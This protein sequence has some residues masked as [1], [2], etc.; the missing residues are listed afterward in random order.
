M[1]G[2]HD[3]SIQEFARS[4]KDKYPDYE[5]VPD[6]E[7]AASILTKFPEYKNRVRGMN[8]PGVERLNGL[9]VQML[10]H[11]LNLYDQFQQQGIT[12][13]IKAGFRT[14]EQEY[15]LFTHGYPT[16]GNTGYGSKISPHQEGRAIDFSFAPD[17]RDKGRTILAQYAQANGLHIPSDEPWHVA[18]PKGA[19]A[20]G[21]YERN[22]DPDIDWLNPTSVQTWVES[23]GDIGTFPQTGTELPATTSRVP[24]EPSTTPPS[25]PA[26]VPLSVYDA[27]WHFGMTPEQARNLTPKARQVLAKAVVGDQAKKAQGQTIP[28]PPLRYQNERRKEAGLTPLKFNT[29]SDENAPSPYYKPDVGSLKGFGKM[30][31]RGGFWLPE[32]SEVQRVLRTPVS[33]P[34]EDD[35]WN[36]VARQ[37]LFNEYEAERTRVRHPESGEEQPRQIVLSQIPDSAVARRAAELK[38]QSEESEVNAGSG[39][40]QFTQRM[41]DLASSPLGST[42]QADPDIL[43]GQLRAVASTLKQIPYLS[44]GFGALKLMGIDPYGDVA[45]K[46]QA[47]AEVQARRTEPTVKIKIGGT[48]IPV[49]DI[50]RG[51]KEGIGSA[52][53]EIPKLMLGSELLTVTG[54]PVALNLPIQGALSRADEGVPGVIKGAVGGLVYHYGGQVTGP[55]LG[56]TSN[57]LLWIGAPAAEA[58]IANPDLP[59]SQAI[60]QTLAMGAFAGFGGGERARVFDAEGNVRIARIRDIPAIAQGKLSFV[61]PVLQ[62]GQPSQPSQYRHADFGVVTEADNQSGIP[63][64]KVRVTDEQGVDHVIVKPSTARNQRAIPLEK[65]K[66]DAE[67]EGTSIYGETGSPSTARGAVGDQA[68]SAATES[69]IDRV[70]YGQQAEKERLTVPEEPAINQPLQTSTEVPQQPAIAPSAGV[71]QPKRVASTPAIAEHIRKV[72]DEPAVTQKDTRLVAYDLTVPDGPPQRVMLAIKDGVADV[73]V[74]PPRGKFMVELDERNYD[75]IEGKDRVSQIPRGQVGT[76]QVLAVKRFLQAEHPEIKKFSF[77]RAGSTG[78][79]VGRQRV[80]AAKPEVPSVPGAI[81]PH[82]GRELELIQNGQKPIALFQESDY[83]TVLKAKEQGLEVGVFGANVKSPT[84]HVAEAAKFYVVGKDK[85]DLF[86]RGNKLRDALESGNY[87]E[88]GRL[89][90]YSAADVKAYEQNLPAAIAASIQEVN[91]E[92]KPPPPS[93]GGESEAKP[94]ARTQIDL[95]LDS[96]I[97]QGIGEVTIPIPEKNATREGIQKV[98]DHIESRGLTAATDGKVVLVRGFRELG[99]SPKVEG[100]VSVPQSLDDLKAEF[101]AADDNQARVYADSRTSTEEH[102][103]ARARLDKVITQLEERGA[104]IP[105]LARSQRRGLNPPQEVNPETATAPETKP[106]SVPQRS[107]EDV[108]RAI[109]DRETELEKQGID[110]IHL[111]DPSQSKAADLPDSWKPMPDD[112]AALYRERDAI[113]KGEIESNVVSADKQFE[114]LISDKTERQKLVRELLQADVPTA[115][116]REFGREQWR[117]IGEGVDKIMRYVSRNVTHDIPQTAFKVDMRLGGPP[118]D[119]QTR[120]VIYQEAG[121]GPSQETL[122]ETQRWLDHLYGAG[123]IKV[124]GA[125]S[126]LAL[127]EPSPKVETKPLAETQLKPL[128][129]KEPPVAEGYTR[130]YRGTSGP[131]EYFPKAWMA[132]EYPDQFRGRWVTPD[133]EYARQFSKTDAEIAYVDVPTKDLSKYK[134]EGIP[135]TE[136]L[137]QEPGK[138]YLYP[139]APA[140]TGKGLTQAP[141]PLA[142]SAVEAQNIE[143]GQAAQAQSIREPRLP[144]S[145]AATGAETEVS[146]PDSDRTYRARYVV[147]EA[148]DVVPSHNPQTFQPRA[149]Y[150]H[151]NDRQYER[152]PQYQLQ[153][154]D[155]SRPEKFNPRAVVNNSPTVEVGPPVIDADGN[156]LGGNSRAMII[157]RMYEASDP[158]GRDAY[159]KL[160]L[161]QARLYGIDPSEVM[162]MKRPV[163]V[164]ELS[165]AHLERPDVQRIITELNRTSTTPLT[166]G[167]KSSVASR[168]MSDDAAQF[169]SQMIE[170]GGDTATVSSVMDSDGPAIINKLI[171]DGIFQPGERN[172]LFDK[173]GKPTAEAKAQVERILVSGIYHDLAQMEATPDGVRRNIERL[174]IPLR[175]IAGTEWDLSD[176]VQTAIDA[177]QEARNTTGGNLD[178]LVGQLSLTHPPYAGDEIALAKTLRLGPRRTAEKFRGYAN[179]YADAQ[180]GGG[181]FGAP[182]Q[183]ESLKVHFGI[184]TIVRP[185]PNPIINETSNRIIAAA[186]EGNLNN[187][188]AAITQAPPEARMQIQGLVSEIAKEQSSGTEN[189][190]IIGRVAESGQESTKVPDYDQGVKVE[191]GLGEVPGE[192]QAADV[193]GGSLSSEGGKVDVDLLTL[194]VRPFAKDVAAKAVQGARGIRDIA[195]AVRGIL[196]PSTRS[197][198]AKSTALSTRA[199]VGEMERQNAIAERSLEGARKFFAGQAPDSNYE[200]I[201]KM[202]RGQ[203]QPDPNTQNFGDILRQSFDLR[204]DQI[205]SL[206]TG[207]LENFIENYFPHIWKD[208][209]KASAVFSEGRRPFEGKK[210]FLKQRTIPFTSDGLAAGLEPISSN[211][212]DLAVLKLREMDKYLMAHRVLDEMKDAGTLKFFKV[213]E[214]IPDGWKQIDDRVSTVYSRGE[215]GE[216]ILRGRYAAPESAAKIINNYLSPGIEATVLREPFKAWRATANFMNQFQLG[217][218]AFHAG[219][220]TLD[221]AISRTAVGLEDILAYG[222][223]IRGLKTI[224]STP[225][226]P[227]TNLIQG[228]K[229]LR[230]YYKPGS[231]GAE[232]GQYVDALVQGGGRAAQDRFYTN[233]AIRSFTDALKQGNIIGSIF[234]APGAAVELLAKPTMEFLVPRQKMGVFAEMAKREL[235]RLGPNA[236]QEQTREAMARAWDSVDNRMGQMIYDNLFWH[237]ITKD[238]AM[239][240]VR[241]VGWNLGTM[242]EVGGGIADYV[243]LPVRALDQNRTNPLFTHRMAYTAALPLIVG[244]MGA[245]TQY[246][247]TGKGPDELKDYFFPKTGN[248][249]ENGS[250]E[251]IAFP[252]YMKDIFPLVDRAKHGDVAGMISTAGHMATSKAHPLIGLVGEMLSNKDYYGTEIR[253]PDDPV[254]Q[255]LKDVAAH[256]GESLIPFAIRGY[257]KEQERDTAMWRRVLPFVGITPAPRYLNQSEAEKLLT[258]KLKARIPQGARSRDQAERSQLK[259]RVEAAIRQRKEVSDEDA[260]AIM[261]LTPTERKAM[262]VASHKE[263]LQLR[264]KQL[265]IED[266][267]DVY[268]KMTPAE[269]IKVRP[270]LMAKKLRLAGMTP[271]GENTQPTELRGTLAEKQALRD[272]LNKALGIVAV[273][274]P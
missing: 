144:T 255:Q 12:P 73:S 101:A 245:M 260:A 265:G 120:L 172:T 142:S 273:P 8:A 56:R 211:P 94:A 130:L 3:Y 171:E 109:D 97:K 106:P 40:G 123:E 110:V 6:Y 43:R 111:Y 262:I 4:I 69:Q 10:Q 48:Q 132:S 140:E 121:L 162:A 167:E 176:K 238:L 170:R 99:A 196:A 7:L 179:D 11:Y 92:T 107:Y 183:A 51:V 197:P 21:G 228:S 57:T 2:E 147:R 240:S 188:S 267:L 164:R 254:V 146:I 9:S 181:L 216:I 81:G 137:F 214:P 236:T 26:S 103:A 39:I 114:P 49:G 34:T 86:E 134:A 46:I 222:K 36:A 76:A 223:P 152:E 28:L 19:P 213:S 199:N 89:L 98:V 148:E 35:H 232:I 38:Q 47:G 149:D 139:A 242:R 264:F 153:V 61:P 229:M 259:H 119:I 163:L 115:L 112:L 22:P 127:P 63:R 150:Y 182:T 193:T 175:R 160:L 191:P 241:S 251:R 17:Q 58:K 128:P 70:R 180:S 218:S 266:A 74:G 42:S 158:Q 159:R 187:L 30:A 25:Q 117:G 209:T 13:T 138:E 227:I 272:R 244:T 161:D 243:S 203:P 200:F 68:R 192:P 18:I 177:I 44:P 233:Q 53:I 204:R 189:P 190:S 247:L 151:V 84:G 231:Q 221:A 37:Q 201:D 217:F 257:Q 85:A 1:N 66:A 83:S 32:E 235:E 165:D 184:D 270:E 145:P 113:D 23:R 173:T 212:I 78:G 252:S 194:G 253:N 205:R 268:E 104:N 67:R 108:Q 45:K 178:M 202:E 269:K 41:L 141:E 93:E 96:A 249:D 246:L 157:Q 54:L 90:G 77:V 95:I 126:A 15:Y 239:S 168:Q 31:N 154:M 174:A 230:E 234:R 219:F 118:E 16:K 207:K 185:D 215:S 124:P 256:A 102:R 24:V 156:V 71:A 198:E 136:G 274:E 5:Q 133:K 129:A 125:K 62:E 29:A 65:E 100:G 261:D 258:E 82:Q 208:P 91:P 59:W 224:A 105:A 169:V 237:K 122:N 210:S 14:A 226:S 271:T 60:A 80:L 55:Y 166:P 88:V 225:I 79:E 20:S 220:T 64:G 116:R 33:T 131:P 27:A 195:D 248:L 52:T 50:A 143:R 87:K 186:E 206:G 263:P 72:F 75:Y 135:G 155:R 250:P